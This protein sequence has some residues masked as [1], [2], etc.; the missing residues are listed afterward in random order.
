MTKR[1][2][3]SKQ[4]YVPNSAPEYF[5]KQ[6]APILADFISVPIQFHF[7]PRRTS[8]P[9][10]LHSRYC[11]NLQNMALAVTKNMLLI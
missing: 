8:I 9:S 7:H 4:H 6:T 1:I 5:N 11:S 10:L 3:E 2:L